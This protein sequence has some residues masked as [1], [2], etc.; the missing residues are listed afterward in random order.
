MVQGTNDTTDE[1]LD[2]GLHALSELLGPGWTVTKLADPVDPSPRAASV[3]DARVQVTRPD[4]SR[5]TEFLVMVRPTVTPRD[6]EERIAPVA[7]IL[8]HA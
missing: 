1:V 3:L 8:R 6:V 5:S 2:Q 7:G 4:Q